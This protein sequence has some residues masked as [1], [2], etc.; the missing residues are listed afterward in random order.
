MIRSRKIPDTVDLRFPIPSAVHVHFSGSVGPRT[1]IFFWIY[2]WG[3]ERND[4]GK[5][6]RRRRLDGCVDVDDA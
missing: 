4:R 3:K 6:K 2:I 1:V 5:I